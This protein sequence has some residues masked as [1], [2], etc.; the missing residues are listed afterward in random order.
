MCALSSLSKFYGCYDLWK[1]IIRK[2]DLKWSE[3]NSLEAFHAIFSDE[4]NYRVMIEWLQRACASVPRSY[5]NLLLFDALTGLRADEA[6]QSI[7]LLHSN[8]GDYLNKEHMILEHYKI[9]EVFIRTT[10]K[11]FIS[12]MTEKV[13]Q[14]AQESGVYNYNTMRHML[15]RKGLG[16]NMGYCR[17]IFGT[18]L[19]MNGIESEIVDLLEGRISQEVFVRHYFR[20]DFQ[21]EIGRIRSVLERLY[22]EIVV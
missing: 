1:E 2:H 19:R 5:A 21:K 14:V 13:L 22:A 3:A 15:R 8:K 16:M 17:K 11:A 20:P 12:I 4:K 10:K 9:P 18:Y 7:R 6:C